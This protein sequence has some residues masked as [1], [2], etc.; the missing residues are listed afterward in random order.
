[1]DILSNSINEKIKEIETK[2]Q[3]ITYLQ[4]FDKAKE[5]QEKFGQAKEKIEAMMQA[6]SQTHL[7]YHQAMDAL[8][9]VDFEIDDY[10]QN[11]GKVKE[12]ELNRSVFLGKLEQFIGDTKG[13]STETMLSGLR[14]IVQE[15]K[16]LEV[17]ESLFSKFYTLAAGALLSTFLKQ[18]QKR[19][20]D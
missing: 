19:R 11:E 14:E 10:L 4:E 17:E 18:A 13:K 7:Y 2:I 20:R 9:V 12:Q 1:M 5:F 8:D 6:E 16:E 15:I 3:K